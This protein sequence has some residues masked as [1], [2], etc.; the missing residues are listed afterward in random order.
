ME[1]MYNLNIERAI[2]SSMLFT[3]WEPDIQALYTQLQSYDFYLPFHQN[4]YS[5]CYRLQAEG[6]PVD[7]EFTRSLLMREGKFDEIAMLDILTANTI[8]NVAAYVSDLKQKSQARALVALSLEIK[9]GIAQDGETPLEMIEKMMRRLENIAEGGSLRIKRHSIYEVTAK[10]PE[11]YCKEWLPIPKGTVT[12]LSAPGGTG[13]TWLVLQ[14]AYRIA[15]EGKRVFLWLSEDPAGIVRKRYDSILEKIVQSHGE[16]D[17][18]MLDVSFDAP[19]QMLESSGRSMKMSAKFFA[20]K[21]ELSEYDVVVLDPLL[22]FYGG[23]ENDNSHARIFMQP[24]LNWVNG[25]DKSIVFLHHSKKGDGN[26]S[27]RSRGAGAIVDAARC[28]Y[29]VDK[30]YVNK[31]GRQETDMLS[32]HMRKITLTKDNYGASQHLGGFSVERE[33]TPKN[34][35]R[36]FIINYEINENGG[37]IELPMII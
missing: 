16:L 26:G 28:V 5:T 34:S 7:E 29:D 35:A 22:A 21:R 31:S 23:D 3:P 19:M 15:K 14:L 10:E 36:E 12:L 4:L 25:G 9:K 30:I 11:F 6:K 17:R 33:I 13:K 2:L 37:G 24:F 27:T 18:G 32:L 8:S 20:M 1:N